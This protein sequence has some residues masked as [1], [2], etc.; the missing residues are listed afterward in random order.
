MS[1]PF[2]LVEDCLVAVAESFDPPNGDAELDAI[3]IL[4]R[5]LLCVSERW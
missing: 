3:A 4:T 2:K 1:Y 5:L